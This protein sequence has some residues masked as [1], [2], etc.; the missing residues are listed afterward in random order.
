MTDDKKY[1]PAVT[2]R[3][4][5][6]TTLADAQQM[7]QVFVDAGLFDVTD[8]EAQAGMTPQKKA[9]VATV[10]IVAGASM[11]L[12][13]FASMRGLHVIKGKVEPGYQTLLAVLVK[14][15]GSY[16]IHKREADGAIIEFFGPTGKSLGTASHDAADQAREGLGGDNWRKFPRQMHLARAVRAGFDAYCAYL[17]EGPA[18]TGS[19]QDFDAVI[20]AEGFEVEET[21]P[22]PKQSAPE[23]KPAPKPSTVTSPAAKATT[24]ETAKSAS[25]AQPS[26][27]PSTTEGKESTAET[28]SEP[29]TAEAAEDIPDAE[30]VDEIQQA[31]DGE[32]PGDQQLNEILQTGLS[33]GWSEDQIERWLMPFLESKGVDIS[34]PTDSIFATWNFDIVAEAI[35]HLA[36]NQPEA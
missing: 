34:D 28:G 14:N 31:S 18:N 4:F 19:D 2:A 36:N 5:Q 33:N 17:L 23:K 10:K 11:G 26:T 15:G 12:S 20:E 32:V 27:T 30:E 6:I 8:R 3:P 35:N 16:K 24:P 21:T 22:T 1:L 29:A 25:T 9:A 13:P 7:G